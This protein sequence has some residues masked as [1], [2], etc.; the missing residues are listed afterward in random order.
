LKRPRVGFFLNKN[1]FLQVNIKLTTT[2]GAREGGRRRDK[3]GYSASLAHV[4]FWLRHRNFAVFIEKCKNL[5]AYIQECE[6]REKDRKFQLDSLSQGLSKRK[7]Y[8]YYGEEAA[9]E[10]GE[11]LDGSLP[12][13][14]AT[15]PGPPCKKKKKSAE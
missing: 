14:A 7:N 8:D 10:Q 15:E 6:A 9:V 3:Y 12:P 1:I 5:L 11:L 13:A 2:S 4:L